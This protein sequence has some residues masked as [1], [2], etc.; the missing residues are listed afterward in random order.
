MFNDTRALQTLKGLFQDQ[1]DVLKMLNF[2]KLDLK[3]LTD[4]QLILEQ[5]QRK[6]YICFTG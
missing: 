4:K 5:N 6:L 1:P 3:H 2:R